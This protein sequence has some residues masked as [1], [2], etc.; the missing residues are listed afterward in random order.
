MKGQTVMFKIKEKLF[1]SKVYDI[2]TVAGQ[3]AH[4]LNPK[5]ANI[6]LLSF[7]LVEVEN[8]PVWVPMGECEFLPDGGL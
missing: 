4:A 3:S 6:V 2:H 1:T 8:R 5:Q 7:L